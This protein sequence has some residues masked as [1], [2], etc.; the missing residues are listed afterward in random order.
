MQ[1]QTNFDIPPYP[2]PI[3][4][5]KTIVTVGSCFSTVI[6]NKLLE[7]KFEVL[8]NPFGTIFNPLSLFTL[9]Q[10]SIAGQNLPHEMVIGFQGRYLHYGCHSEISASS[11]TGLLNKIQQAIEK[12][13]LA[14][15]HASHLIITM[16]TTYVYEHL[17]FNQTVA[18]CHKQPAKLF[19]KRSL[20]ILEMRSA[21]EA[22]ATP[23]IAINPN[24]NIILTVSPVRHIKDGIPENQYSKSLLRVFC[25]E[26]ET[27][28]KNVSYFPSYEIMLDEL[29]DYR[30]YKEDMIHPSSQAEQYIWEKFSKSFLTNDTQKTV[31]RIEEIIRSLSHKPFNP[32]GESHQ[33]FLKNLLQ[34]MEQMTPKIDFTSEVNFVKSQILS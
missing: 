33:A 9:L 22:L 23:L 14:L 21:F 13:A 6:G 12:T 19:K 20:D 3:N 30:F 17:Q 5:D 16:G 31:L 29:R 28:F 2:T 15:S 24:L 11:K 10:K 8:N 26:L 27:F 32:S 34:K 25:H 1:L 4:Y 18:N 7:R